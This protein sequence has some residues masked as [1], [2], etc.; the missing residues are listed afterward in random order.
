VRVPLVLWNPRLFAGG[1]RSGTIVSH[2][3]LAPTVLDLLGVAAP[4][5]WQGRSAFAA[6]RPPRAY[7]YA[8]KGEFLLGVREERWKYIVDASAGREMLFDLAADPTE[9][10]DL[11]SGD[12]AR[13]RRLRQRL[14]AWVD[15]ERRRL[16]AIEG[17]PP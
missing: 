11:A 10:R 1:A 13:C 3:D 2:V 17:R 15:F 5:G 9:Q 12:P 16:A 7:F 8:G 6:D 4:A 14:A